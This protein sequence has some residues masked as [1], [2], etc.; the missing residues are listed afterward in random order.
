VGEDGVTVAGAG[1]RAPGPAAALA[2][3]RP[4]PPPGGEP[5]SAA[6]P[7]VALPGA[8]AARGTLPALPFEAPALDPPAPRLGAAERAASAVDAIVARDRGSLELRLGPDLAIRLELAAPAAVSLRVDAAPPVA[9][10]AR[11]E[12]PALAAAIAARGVKVAGAEVVSRRAP[13][14][15]GRRTGAR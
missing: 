15:G 9:P 10:A 2:S 11:A 6:P 1:P 4:R 14:Q 13:R 12:L 3:R 8:D 5:L 7:A